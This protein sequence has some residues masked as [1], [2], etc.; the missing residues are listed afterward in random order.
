M[1]NDDRGLSWIGDSIQG[2]SLYF[3]PAIYVLAGFLHISSP[4]TNNST[5]TSVYCCAFYFA[6]RE[7]LST[8]LGGLCK[9][10]EF[11]G[12]QSLQY[13]NVGCNFV[14]QPFT[15]YGNATE[16]PLRTTE[17]VD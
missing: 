14:L 6:E 2:D 16:F 9:S 12:K 15:Q 17:S 13:V 11:R 5:D 1:G 3:C 8:Q 7:S 4:C 10:F